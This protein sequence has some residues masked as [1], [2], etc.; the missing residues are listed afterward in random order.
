M[1][2]LLRKVFNKDLSQDKGEEMV[3]DKDEDMRE[4]LKE[5]LALQKEV[6]VQTQNW[7]R[8]N[9]TLIVATNT[10]LL[11]AAAAFFTIYFRTSTQYSPWIF[12]LP[13]VISILGL[14]ITGYLTVQYNNS[15]SR[16]VVYEK[17]FG[18]HKDN[19][20]ISEVLTCLPSLK[21]R[22]GESFV[23]KFYHQPIKGLRATSWFFLVVHLI[24]LAFS[25]YFVYSS[26]EV[27]VVKRSTDNSQANPTLNLCT[28]S[29]DKTVD[30]TLVKPITH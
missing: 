1:G 13:G 20:G 14:I 12:S 11:G 9:E 18:M 24:V 29:E 3:T 19:A 10:V 8:H 26:P 2:E 7:A 23:P 28:I 27:E 25:S 5:K 6:Y 4:N 17:Y 22:W 30:C 21:E 16:L 15:I